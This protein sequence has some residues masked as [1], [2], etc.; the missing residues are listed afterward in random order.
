MKPYFACS[1]TLAAI[2]AFNF[3]LNTVNFN[4]SKEFA[5]VDFGWCK[6][7]GNANEYE[8][9][10]A[11]LYGS[12][13]GGGSFIGGILGSL[14][15]GVISK[16]GRR[17]AMIIIHAINIV[18]SLISTAAQCFSMLLLGRLIAGVSV[19]MSG[20]I[21]I[22]LTEICTVENRGTYGTAYPMFITMGQL[23]MS[24][25][26]LLHMR[27]L[28]ATENAAGADAITMMDRFVWRMA[29]FWPAVFSMIAL[30]IIY[31]VVKH[32]TPHVLLQEGKEDEAKEVIELL[33]GSEKADTVFAE[34][35]GDVEA[36]QSA[37]TSLGIIAAL[38]VP[39]YRRAIFIICGLSIMQQL[40]GIN[41]FVANASK[42][43]VSIMGRSFTASAMSLAGVA[44]LFV[45]TLF[46]AFVIDKFGRKTLFL[47]GIAVSCVSMV[48]AVIIKMSSAEKWASY[49]MVVGCIGFMIGFAIGFGGIMWLYFAEALGTE[50]KDA[51]FGVATS[52]NWLFAAIVVISSDPLLA[53]NDKVAYSLYTGFG[54]LGFAFVYFFLKETK[55]MPLGQAF[56]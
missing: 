51:A 17:R 35:R 31:V 13:I 37:S 46:L 45:T 33:H 32:D 20:M 39:K 8:C 55:G 50:Y 28:G 15:I 4:A 10:K 3:G 27:V 25:W 12:L 11:T 16:Y 2:V 34:V 40:S 44:A 6:G 19:G 41:V 49:V 47:F 56:A 36:L 26:Q 9:T 53:W 43:F 29:Q 14:L 5:T 18:G 30:A 7:E 42:L 23:L 54:L 52:V 48:P 24:A 1:V 22:Y 38:K 21:A